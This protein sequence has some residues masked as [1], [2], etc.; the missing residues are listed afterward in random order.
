MSPALELQGL[1]ITTLKASPAVMA[2]V[3]GIYD[4]PPDNPWGGLRQAYISL[5]PSDVQIDDA[6]CVAGETHNTQIDVWSRAVG[7][8]QC[9]QIADAIKRA[10]HKQDFTLPTNGFVEMLLTMAHY[11]RDPDGITS[12]AALHFTAMI[13]E[14]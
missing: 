9:K 2:L 6:D 12:H 11:L 10:L 8:P 4:Q 7:M 13:E 1:I 14:V 5:G 3:D